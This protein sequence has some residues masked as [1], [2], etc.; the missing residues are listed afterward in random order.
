MKLM[1]RTEGILLDPVYTSKALAGLVDHVKQGRIGPDQT[2]I[3]VHTGGT[4]ALFAYN[5]EILKVCRARES[6]VSSLFPFNPTS[7]KWIF[8]VGY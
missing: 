8:G 2:V 3:F 7:Q 4:P 5:R 1:A 6:E